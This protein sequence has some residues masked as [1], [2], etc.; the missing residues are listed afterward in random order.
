MA[1]D[2]SKMRKSLQTRQEESTRNAESGG[3]RGF[4]PYIDEKALP[5]PLFKKIPE[6]TIVFDIIPFQVSEKFLI[7]PISRRPQ[8]VPG[9]WY[10]YL[11]LHVHQK[12]GPSNHNVICPKMHLGK[13]CPICDIA[14]AKKQGIE[15]GDKE[16]WKAEVMPFLPK[17][18]SVYQIWIHDKSKDE[19]DKGVQV[20]EISF[21]SLE[22]ELLAIAKDPETDETIDYAWPGIEGK[23]ITF[24]RKGTGMTNTSYVGYKFLDRKEEIPDEIVD[25]TCAINEYITIMTPEEIKKLMNAGEDEDDEEEK[26][27]RGNRTSKDTD[28]DD[29]ERKARPNRLGRK[30][31]DE[32]D[33]DDS[34]D[35]KPKRKAKAGDPEEE[36]EEEVKP[37]RRA[38]PA[39]EPAD[40]EEEKPRSRREKREAEK[41][42]TKP[43]KEN[44]CTFGHKFGVDTDDYEDCEECPEKL[45][46]KCAAKKDDDAD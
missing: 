14:D 42:T 43:K 36:P 6:G 30:A 31:K 16:G 18:R 35:E 23:K 26:P 41:E 37:R 10:Y 40:E 45:Y 21:H 4:I 11:D 44:P 20:L 12:I 9:E 32:D 39:E 28:D 29:S 13:P 33:T 1:I 7:D 2:R 15:F 38:K 17:R 34:E 19:E 25:G 27:R 22:K 3:G 5:I 8:Y 24:T 46:N